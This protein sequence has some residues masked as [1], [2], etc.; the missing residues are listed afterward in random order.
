MLEGLKKTFGYSEEKKAVSL[1]DPAAFEIFGTIPTASGAVV[2]AHT[3][4]QVPAVLQAVRLQRSPHVG[5][6]RPW[7]ALR[8]PFHP[9]R[10]RHLG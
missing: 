2:N 9:K 8:G 1:T 4:L 6:R 7:A 3:A 5:C 10:H